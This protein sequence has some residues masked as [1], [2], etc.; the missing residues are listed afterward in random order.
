M[1]AR[2]FSLSILLGV[3]GCSSE[4]DLVAH[5]TASAALPSPAM[6]APSSG[7]TIVV[8]EPYVMP[9]GAKSELVCVGVDVPRSA[10][11]HVVSIVPRIDNAK[12]LVGMR[13]FQAGWSVSSVPTPC[14]RYETAS[15]RLLH[16][17]T[18]G[19]GGL[20]LPPE[21][22]FP[23]EPGTTHW[24]VQ[25]QYENVLGLSSGESD[26]SG[27]ELET[28]EALRPNDAGVF[29][30]GAQQPMTIP[31]RA[32]RT[33][34]CENV[35]WPQWDAATIFAASV[36]MNRLGRSTWMQRLSP[37][38]PTLLETLY[39][40]STFEPG[41]R[42]S[43]PISTRT[44]SGDVIRTRCGWENLGDEPVVVGDDADD[45][46]CLHVVAYYPDMRVP[47]YLPAALS[48]CAVE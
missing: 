32:K 41:N 48:R 5:T 11:R 14:A 9:S 6:P 33:L 38:D 27:Y 3:V 44:G 13:L 18:P 35:L 1:H 46:R 22:G 36:E 12:I 45:E 23:E 21:A 29:A 2:I 7:D 28:T 4:P 26:R 25:L 24:A 20:E 37:R 15:W 34:T 43:F 39:A 42:P 31:P 8:G 30:F 10:K 16:V 47:W 17:W 40:S 19:A